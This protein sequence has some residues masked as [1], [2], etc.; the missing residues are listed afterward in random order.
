MRILK[1]SYLPQH[2]LN[3]RAHSLNKRHCNDMVA[4]K[5]RGT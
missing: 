1:M 2:M 4:L 5:I 3:K